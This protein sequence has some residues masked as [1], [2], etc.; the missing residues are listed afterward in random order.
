[1]QVVF[2]APSAVLC[3]VQGL[4]L[5]LSLLLSKGALILLE[6]YMRQCVCHPSFKHLGCCCLHTQK[7]SSTVLA[8]S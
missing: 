2:A 4:P 3:T 5:A 1:M 6:G 8:M 7:P